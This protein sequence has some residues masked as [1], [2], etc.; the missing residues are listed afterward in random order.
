MTGTFSAAATAVSV[1]SEGELTPRSIL[2]SMR[3]DM[4]GKMGNLGHRHLELFAEF[5][6][7]RADGFGKPLFVGLHAATARWGSFDFSHG[8]FGD[9]DG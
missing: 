6:D 3:T 1:L 4:P 5:A 9:G 2:D 8:S 7:L